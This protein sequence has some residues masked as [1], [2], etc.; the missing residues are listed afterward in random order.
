MRA[1]SFID[2]VAIVAAHVI[3]PSG[4]I[5]VEFVLIVRRETTLIRRCGI[6]VARAGAGN[7]VEG[8]V[9]RNIV[10]SHDLPHVR[11]VFGDVIAVV[12]AGVVYPFGVVLVELALIM[13]GKPALI[14]AGWI[15]IAGTGD[16]G[17]RHIGRDAIPAQDFLH[18]FHVFRNVVPI[19]LSFTHLV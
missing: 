11:G 7:L 14:S 19:V 18:V 8:H 9:D 5:L 3:C 16:L 2:V 1:A 17:I 6:A 12:L 10:A 4:I 13:R 15:F